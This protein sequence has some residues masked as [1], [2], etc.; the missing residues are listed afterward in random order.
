M[1]PKCL[2]DLDRFY[3][4]EGDTMVTDERIV[5]PN[6]GYVLEGAVGECYRG[7]EHK[8]GENG[9]HTIEDD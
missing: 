2:G 8:A 5:C 9:K 1:C 4:E 7:D 6:C 3:I